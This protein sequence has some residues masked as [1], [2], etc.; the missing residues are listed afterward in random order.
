[1]SMCACSSPNQ[2]SC[3]RTP[4]T[5][6]NGSSCSGWA[7]DF[8]SRTLYGKDLL[9]DTRREKRT[10]ACQEI[11][12]SLQNMPE[13]M[14]LVTG[15]GVSI[16]AGMPNWVKLVSKM[17][18]S[19][20]YATVH[21][22]EDCK[23]PKDS[24]DSE[25]LKLYRELM[26]GNLQI[27]SDVNTLESAEYII[28]VLSEDR[29]VALSKALENNALQ[30][31]IRPMI[32]ASEPAEVFLKKKTGKTDIPTDSDEKLRLARHTE[33]TL[34]AAAYL[35][36][37]PQGFKRTMT[38]N[39]DTLLQEYLVKVFGLDEAEL[40]THVDKHTDKHTD[41]PSDIR[42]VF[43]LHGCIPRDANMSSATYGHRSKEIIL[44]EDSYYEVEKT[45]SY[46]WFNSVQSYYLNYGPCVFVGFSGDDYNF[47]RILRQLGHDPLQHHYIVTT[48]DDVYKDIYKGICLLHRN[49]DGSQS[50]PV[51]E[52]SR[53]ARLLLD[54]VL[55][56]KEDYWKDHGF[57]PIWVTIAEIPEILVS[58]LP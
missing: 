49:K 54:R 53:Q 6:D 7:C 11:R 34:A 55:K 28:K 17:L 36:W 37:H 47:R 46:N 41:K 32:E 50:V 42:Q 40:V 5:G 29:Q 23:N 18:G 14:T 56:S 24:I 15:A 25:L 33:S 43:H 27:L 20:L 45:G 1:M 21:L 38:Y 16:P 22:R 8:H 52:I 19:A 51:E 30:S 12:E 57:T 2:I 4:L 31:I 44:S 35:M 58:L 9:L 26:K 48:I 10:A 39:Y 13:K 3:S